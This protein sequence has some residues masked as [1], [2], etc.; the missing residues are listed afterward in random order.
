M[1]VNCTTLYD[2]ESSAAAFHIPADFDDIFVNLGFGTLLL[3]YANQ[4]NHLQALFQTWL[5]NNTNFVEAVALLKKYA[6]RPQSGT[7][8]S[9]MVDPR[10]FLYLREY[11]YQMEAANR[12]GAFAVTW[13]LN[14]SEDR[15]THDSYAMPFNTNNI[16]LT[17]CSNVVYGLTAAVLA[18]LGDPG[19][20][21]W[22][23]AEIQ[24]IYEN[25]TDLIV[26]AIEQNFS[27]RPD[28][29]LTYYPSVFNF[30]W[31]TTR[32]L[33]LIQSYS[34]RHDGVL[35]PFPVLGRVKERLLVAMRNVVT[36]T[37][38]KMATQDE[39]GAT[40]CF[41]EFLGGNDRTIL[42]EKKEHNKILLWITNRKIAKFFSIFNS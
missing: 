41:D 14:L 28:I 8:D 25:T 3:N 5:K 23:D 30:Y 32:T 4:T 18:R 15:E 37:V 22:F 38:L 34:A 7:L 11:L 9:G 6:Y 17:V 24:M 19:P 2:R 26:W 36:P 42:G 13:A 39:Q 35:P 1:M 12:T 31:F 21:E 33:N 29:A 20:E 27:G 40:A 10:T 16:D